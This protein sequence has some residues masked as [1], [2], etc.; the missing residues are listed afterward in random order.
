MWHSAMH[1]TSRLDN[2]LDLCVC[3]SERE[4]ELAMFENVLDLCACVRERAHAMSHS[5]IHVTMF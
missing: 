2:I 3:E 4:C 5:A 1:L